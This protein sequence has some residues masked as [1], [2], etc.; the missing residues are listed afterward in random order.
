[1]YNL[2]AKNLYD[3][4]NKDCQIIVVGDAKSIFNLWYVLIKKD[5]EVKIFDVAN[6]YEVDPSKGLPFQFKI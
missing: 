1:M 6:S 5:Y 2:I 3:Y 4:Y